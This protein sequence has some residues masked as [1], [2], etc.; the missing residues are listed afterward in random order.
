MYGSHTCFHLQINSRAKMLPNTPDNVSMPDP[1][2]QYLY[3]FD[4]ETFVSIFVS[5]TFFIFSESALSFQFHS[6]LSIYMNLKSV[7]FL[8]Y[9]ISSRFGSG[10]HILCSGNKQWFAVVSTVLEHD[11]AVSSAQENFK[12][13]NTMLCNKDIHDCR[14]ALESISSKSLISRE[15]VTT[16]SF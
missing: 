2:N 13:R 7:M 8:R 12:A 11:N 1:W 3:P 10:C 9:R 5:L 16:A 14:L 15:L 6:S 4:D